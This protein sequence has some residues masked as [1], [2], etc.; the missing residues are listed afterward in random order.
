M[1]YE[2][3]PLKAL[4]QPLYSTMEPD[5]RMCYNFAVEKCCLHIF[6]LFP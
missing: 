3:S 4:Y 1:G 6:N 2:Q 5:S